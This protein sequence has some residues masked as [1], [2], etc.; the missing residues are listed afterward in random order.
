MP[1]IDYRAARALLPLADVLALLGFVPRRRHGLQLR[2]PCPVHRCRSAM[3][4]SFAAH[5][6]QNAWHC[7][8]CG[9]GGNALDLWAA[10]TQ[11]PLP[12]AILDLCQRLGRAVPWLPPH[13]AGHAP[14]PQKHR[15][16]N[17]E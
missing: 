7:F 4:R 3:S 9:A 10:V 17:R 1:G 15:C 2:G 6:G 13:H 14:A 8:R 5:L 16:R 11:Q 12:A